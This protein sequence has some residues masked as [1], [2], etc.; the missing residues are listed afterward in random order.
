MNYILISL[1]SLLFASCEKKITHPEEVG[2]HSFELLQNIS[3]I[4][5]EKY[6]LSFW[7]KDEIK[8]HLKDSPF[9]ECNRVGY[10]SSKETKAECLEILAQEVVEDFDRHYESIKKFGISNGIVWKDIKY[11]DYIYNSTEYG[12]LSELKGDVYFKYGSQRYSIRVNAIYD[13]RQYKFI[14]IS[15]PYPYTE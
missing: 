14:E 12:D 2:V 1:I 4:S 13:G 11:I 10:D 5:K 15:N 9:A 6:K 3:T 7:S 8:S